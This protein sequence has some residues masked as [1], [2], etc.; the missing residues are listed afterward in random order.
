MYKTVDIVIFSDRQ[1]NSNGQITHNAESH[2]YS[3]R[4]YIEQVFNNIS[5]AM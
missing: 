1:K 4:S 2:Q 3:F 5:Y